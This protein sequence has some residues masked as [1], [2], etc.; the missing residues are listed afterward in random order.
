M[1]FKHNKKRNT[2]FLYETLLKE[3]SKYV[4]RGDKDRKNKI[5]SILK[6]FFSQ[7]K[8][9]KKELVNVSSVNIKKKILD[10]LIFALKVCKHVKSNAIVLAKNKQT[11][12][13][14]A[15]QM[16]RADST[17][18]AINK[19]NVKNKNKKFVATSDAFFPFTDNIK[20]LIRNDCEAIAQPSGS[21][22]DRKIIDYAKKKKLPLYFLNFRL[23]KH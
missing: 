16:S 21:K 10:D 5:L 22:N 6:E 9:L 23:F 3:M 14:G 8:I 12:G 19:K 4:V 11:L 7:G 20:K 1:R 15:G 17:N 18:I 13:I 2:A